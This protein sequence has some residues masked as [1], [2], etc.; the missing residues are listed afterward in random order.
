M[1]SLYSSAI[2]SGEDSVNP[3]GPPTGPTYQAA[4]ALDNYLAA[5]GCGDCSSQELG[6]LTQAFKN[7]ASAEFPGR[8]SFN[9]Q[10]MRAFGP[11]TD[12]ALS[13]VLR[14]A[15]RSRGACTDS[16]GRCLGGSSP[17]PPAPPGPPAPVPVPTPSATSSGKS[18]DYTVPILVGAGLVAAGIVAYKVYGKK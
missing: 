10:Q 18:A 13:S 16:N 9:A 12:T 11:G 15:R 6:D 8:F 3:V 2:N 5:N 17:R 7:A 1:Y 14:S 4:L